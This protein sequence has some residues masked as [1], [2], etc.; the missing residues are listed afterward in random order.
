MN[1]HRYGCR[2]TRM[3]NRLRIPMR[4]RRFVLAREPRAHGAELLHAQKYLPVLAVLREIPERLAFPGRALRL[5]PEPRLR[6]LHL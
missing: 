2:L 5:E 3:G 6:C 4:N 1:R